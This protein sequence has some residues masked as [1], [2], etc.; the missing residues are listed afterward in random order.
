MLY[1]TINSIIERMFS[2]QRKLHTIELA[3][4]RGW[5]EATFS[6]PEDA[7]NFIVQSADI[8]LYGYELVQPDA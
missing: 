5:Y 6:A 4:G 2:A 8:R 1:N 3:E 7:F